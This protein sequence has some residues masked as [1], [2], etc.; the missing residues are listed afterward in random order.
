MWKPWQFQAS[1]WDLYY[2]PMGYF[3]DWKKIFGGKCFGNWSHMLWCEKT[4]SL[5]LYILTSALNRT[6]QFLKRKY[7]MLWELKWTS[8]WLEQKPHTWFL[9][10]WHKIQKPLIQSSA[11]FSRFQIALRAAPKLKVIMKIKLGISQ[12]KQRF[13]LN[14]EKKLVETGPWWFTRTGYTDC[15]HTNLAALESHLWTIPMAGT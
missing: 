11:C 6:H 1:W 3:P 14:P 13:G 8:T 12:T 9:C 10:I 15:F 2:F 7:S 5:K 4:A